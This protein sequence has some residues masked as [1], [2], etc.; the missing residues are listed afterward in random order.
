[1]CLCACAW[2][3]FL[4]ETTIGFIESIN[5]LKYL[6]INTRNR[7]WNKI[8]YINNKNIYLYYF[9]LNNT[10]YIFILYY[11][12]TI[13]NRNNINYLC[14]YRFWNNLLKK[15]THQI[16]HKQ[17]FRI[18]KRS[19]ETARSHDS[20]GKNE[21]DNPCG[22]PLAF[23][24]L[25]RDTGINV[26][27]YREQRDTVPSLILPSLPVLPLIATTP[28]KA[29]RKIRLSPLKVAAPLPLWDPINTQIAATTN[30]SSHLPPTPGRHRAIGRSLN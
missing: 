28:E 1:M 12:N 26:G 2:I 14:I 15:I 24:L 29:L 20:V 22:R 5:W 10:I 27:I 11:F 18:I 9:L 13:G 21:N 4:F 25:S 17:S 19:R 7:Y 3:R 16:Y 8:I 23:Y 30:S 6:L